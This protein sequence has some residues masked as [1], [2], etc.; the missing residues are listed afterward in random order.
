MLP[1]SVFEGS[2]SSSDPVEVF[3]AHRTII[4]FIDRYLAECTGSE[5]KSFLFIWR[6]THGFRKRSD[7]VGLNQFCGG[8]KCRRT[9]ALLDHGTGLDRNQWSEWQGPAGLRKIFSYRFPLPVEPQPVQ[10]K[11]GTKKSVRK[12]ASAGPLFDKQP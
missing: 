10:P 2:I 8:T 6:R 1:E 9:G 7:E 4:D 12:P 3:E 5:V 11:K